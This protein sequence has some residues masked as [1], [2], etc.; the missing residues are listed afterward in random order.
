MEAEKHYTVH[1]S[2]LSTLTWVRSIQSE[3]VYIQSKNKPYFALI[4]T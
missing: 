4:Y 2:L 3:F 1:K